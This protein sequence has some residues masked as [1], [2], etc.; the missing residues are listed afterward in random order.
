MYGKPLMYFS[1][2]TGLSIQP[3]GTPSLTLT[4]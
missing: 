4:Q 2:N 3:C 1:K